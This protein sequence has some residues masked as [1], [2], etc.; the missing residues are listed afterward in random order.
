MPPTTDRRDCHTAVSAAAVATNTARPPPPST[1]T[2]R[3]TRT[4]GAAFTTK[5]VDP[6]P[7]YWLGMAAVIIASMAEPRARAD[8][9]PTLPAGFEATG[10]M[11]KCLPA[12]DIRDTR[13]LDDRTIL[14]RAHVSD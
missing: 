11:R 9:A 12:H 1:P 2:A 3:S 14:F 4:W 8:E 6:V 13:V 5:T 10:E 7:A